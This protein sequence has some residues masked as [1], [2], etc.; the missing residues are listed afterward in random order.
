MTDQAG[1][2][3]PR[4]CD[5]CGAVGFDKAEEHYNAEACLRSLVKRVALLEGR[6]A[7]TTYRDATP[8]GTIRKPADDLPS[9]PIRSSPETSIK[10][11]GG[12]VD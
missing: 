9:K 5:R 1:P 6:A 7:M 4:R 2:T 3:K 10:S 12:P 8:H 11:N